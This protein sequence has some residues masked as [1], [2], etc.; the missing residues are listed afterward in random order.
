MKFTNKN[1]KPYYKKLQVEKAYELSEKINFLLAGCGRIGQRHA[2]I[3]SS[4]GRLLAVCDID[5]DKAMLLATQYHC[6]YFTS[7]DTMLES[8]SPESL[9]AICTPNYL[10]A[11]QSIAALQ[12]RLHVL[13]EKPMALTTA[14]CAAMI[15]LAPIFTPCPM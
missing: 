15:P 11:Q 13:C 4:L 8:S 6:A 2:Q 14:D 10:H 12:H 5:Q 3:M 7:F 9:V 1:Y